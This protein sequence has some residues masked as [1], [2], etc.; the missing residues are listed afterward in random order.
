MQTVH[1]SVCQTSV[2]PSGFLGPHWIKLISSFQLEVYPKIFF[3]LS[4]IQS[5]ERTLQYKVRKYRNEGIYLASL[6]LPSVTH[7]VSIPPVVFL[8]IMQFTCIILVPPARSL[9][10][11][12]HRPPTFMS[13]I[14][15]RSYNQFSLPLLSRSTVISCSYCSVPSSTFTDFQFYFPLLSTLHIA[16]RI[17]FFKLA[18]LPL[19]LKHLST[20]FYPQNFYDF[21]SVIS[22]HSFPIILQSSPSD[23]L[24]DHP[25][26]KEPDDQPVIFQLKSLSCIP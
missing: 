10:S 19:Y 4:I 1:I 20:S 24:S 25:S 15:L 21:A 17:I 22:C 5:T 12:S 2:R 8:V 11:S 6:N 13:K 26:V 16:A 18:A 7:I 14:H 9:E 23:L 3:T